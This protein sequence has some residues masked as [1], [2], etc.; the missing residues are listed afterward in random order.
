M[1]KIFYLITY[2][3]TVIVASASAQDSTIY[4]LKGTWTV[5][6]MTV[7]IHAQTGGQLIESLEV[8]EKSQMVK[9]G[10]DVFTGLIIMEGRY[11]A[12]RNGISERGNLR[13][14]TGEMF[15]QEE[16]P[17]GIQ[18]QTSPRKYEWQLAGNILTLVLPSSIYRDPN[19]GQFVRGTYTCTYTKMN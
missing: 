11:A 12:E 15:F 8:T 14:S 2:C 13:L 17:P 18:Q 9:Y 10:K 1:H 4:K 7:K 6:K 19:S 3:L 5:Q 16:L